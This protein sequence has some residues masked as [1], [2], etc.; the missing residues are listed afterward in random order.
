MKSIMQEG[1]SVMKAI[2]QAWIKAGK[3]AEFSIKVL[4]EAQKNFLGLTLRSAKIALF[5]DEKTSKGNE[6]HRVTRHFT[7]HQN[8]PQREQREHREPREPRQR[9]QNRDFQEIRET[10]EPRETPH[11]EQREQQPREQREPREHK[12]FTPQW[13]DA[14]I[15]E[16]RLW[17]ST[18][19]D[20]MQKPVPFTV[21]TNNMFLKITFASSIIDPKDKEKHFFAS[22]ATLLLETLKR[23]FRVPLRG[24]KIILTYPAS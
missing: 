9:D 22:C 12:Q 11:R 21:D 17:M 15:Q 24:H 6:P 1:S 19:L 2:E 8:Q 20:E 5:F 7:T 10:R 18:V 14:M 13:N 4:E 23:K 3:P 16:A